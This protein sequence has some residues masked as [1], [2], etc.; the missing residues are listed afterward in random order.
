M[1]SIEVGGPF[2]RVL[3]PTCGRGHFLEGLLD[4]PAPPREIR[5]FEIQPEHAEIARSLADRSGPTR[6]V[7]E[8]ADLFQI[9]LERDLRWL[10]SGP[11]LVVGNLPWVTTAALGASG[12]L[13][14]PVRSNHRKLRG[15]D[16]MTGESNFDISEAIW[17]KLIRELAYESPTI[18]LLCKSAVARNVLRAIQTAN[19]PVTRATLWR[20]DAVRWFRAAVN[21][22]LL[23]V[24]VGPGPKATEAA[25]FADLHS[26]EPESI[27]GIRRRQADRRHRRLPACRLR[28][29]PM[30]ADLATRGQARRQPGH[31]ADPPR[32]WHA[33]ATSWAKSWTSKTNLSIPCSRGPTS[34]A[35]DRSEPT[36]RSSSPSDR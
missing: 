36:D 12:G 11:L 7:V 23:R 35:L 25:V 28:R 26:V 31:G 24:E 17:L 3:E 13:N 6:L 10:E 33:S 18:A 8:V 27:L 5:G 14:G 15:L 30:P 19:L 16:A 21:A 2:P 22:C 9:D 32:R 1:R 20:V 4:R 34:P 29:R